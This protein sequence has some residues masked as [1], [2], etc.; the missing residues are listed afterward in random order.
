M[1]DL[2]SYLRLKTEIE[3][4]GREMRSGA[5]ISPLAKAELG[6]RIAKVLDQ[7]EVL[8][9]SEAYLAMAKDEESAETSL[10]KEEPELPNQILAKRGGFPGACADCGQ[11]E[12]ACFSHL[13]KPKITVRPDRM[14]KVEFPVEYSTTDKITWLKAMRLA[15]IK[16]KGE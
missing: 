7:F 12:C 8:L 2:E 3:R 16:R 13:P 1:A 5:P 10:A 9:K 11:S 14:V 4:L 15:I 6:Q